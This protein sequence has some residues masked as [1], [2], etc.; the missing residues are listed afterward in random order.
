MHFRSIGPARYVSGTLSSG[1]AYPEETTMDWLGTTE[2][3]AAWTDATLSWALTRLRLEAQIEDDSLEI[4]A[5][6]V[7]R[8]HGRHGFWISAQEFREPT[9]TVRLFRPKTPGKF[10]FDRPDYLGTFIYGSTGAR[11]ARSVSI[12]RDAAYRLQFGFDQK[13]ATPR[14]MRL[15]RLADSFHLDLKFALPEPEVRVLGLT[16]RDAP[17]ED[18]WL[19]G[20]WAIPAL[21]DVASSLG[22]RVLQN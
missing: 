17:D 7:H 11:L 9:P 16:W 4:Y 20:D 5:P 15:R 10:A 22:I 13:Y 18:G 19:I 8:A 21:R 1:G 6:D 2:S 14:A 3:L 12:P